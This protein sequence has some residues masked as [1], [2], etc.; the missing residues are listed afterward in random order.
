MTARWRPTA[1]FESLMNEACNPC[2]LKG[3]T[4]LRFQI[5]RSRPST[6]LHFEGD[7]P[8]SVRKTLVK[9]VEAAAPAEPR[10]ICRGYGQ[11]CT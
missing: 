10:R 4:A 1:A 3:G 5:G 7:G 6:D 11:S 8:V 2:V 9:A